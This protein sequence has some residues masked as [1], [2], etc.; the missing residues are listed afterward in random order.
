MVIKYKYPFWFNSMA[1]NSPYRVIDIQPVESSFSKTPSF[2]QFPNGIDLS[3]TIKNPGSFSQW[4]VFGLVV[5]VERWG[6]VIMNHRC[7][8][9]LH[10]GGTVRVSKT[11]QS[12]KPTLQYNPRL[13]EYETITVLT[14]EYY[15]VEVPNIVQL[16]TYN[17][18][19]CR[20]AEDAAISQSEVYV[21]YS[22]SRAQADTSTNSILH[23]IQV[24]DPFNDK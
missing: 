10:L 7:T 12:Y 19:I 2:T 23:S 13:N 3:P 4:Q 17:E 1:T 16:G 15:E 14:Y 8:V 11:R 6:Q 20:Y 24:E 21:E 18:A 9:H 22:G 5:H